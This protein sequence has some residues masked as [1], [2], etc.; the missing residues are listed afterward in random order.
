MFDQPIVFVDLET[1]GGSIIHDRITEIGI[2]QV[3]GETIS[4]WSTLVN[5][6]RPI[7]EFVQQLTGIR[8]DM[9]ADAPT[10]AEVAS[11]LAQPF[12]VTT[13]L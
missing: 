1:T 5:P 8:N 12:A 10:F 3:D 9:V 6:C 13:T 4:T 2:I 11:E 7:P